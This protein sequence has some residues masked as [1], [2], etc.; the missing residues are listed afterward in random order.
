MNGRWICGDVWMDI[1]PTFDHAQLG[2]NLALLYDRFDLLVDKHFDGKTEL[3]IWTAIEIHGTLK[4]QN[5]LSKANLRDFR[6]RTVRCPTK[7]ALRTFRLNTLIISSSHFFLAQWGELVQS[8]AA[9]SEAKTET[10]A[11]PPVPLSSNYRPLKASNGRALRTNINTRLKSVSDGGQCPSRMYVDMG[12]RTNPAR[13]DTKV[14]SSPHSLSRQE[15]RQMREPSGISFSRSGEG[16]PRRSVDVWH[17]VTDQMDSEQ[18]GEA[19]NLLPKTGLDHHH[20]N[21][22]VNNCAVP[23]MAF[24]DCSLL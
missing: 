3:T 1:L 9:E 14:P 20:P 16:H 22:A 17:G 13:T 15:S 21:F 24:D 18:E 23:S 6:C 12:Y 2:L 4:Y 7:S 10:G 19:G 8:E 11:P 5:F